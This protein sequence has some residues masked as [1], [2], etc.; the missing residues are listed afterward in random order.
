MLK[1]NFR[2]TITKNIVTILFYVFLL[3]PFIQSRSYSEMPAIIEKLYK[4][5]AL[6]SSTVI[7][8]D[9]ICSGRIKFKNNA[10]LAL[11][12]FGISYIAITLIM[13]PFSFITVIHKFYIYAAL[14]FFMTTKIKSNPDNILLSLTLIYVFL[15]V[16]NFVFM[17]IYPN[18][19]YTVES[20]HAAHF[21]GD[22][23][24]IGYVVIPGVVVTVLYSHYKYGM[25]KW[26]AI[27]QI[28]MAGFSF[29][30][31]LAMSSIVCF[32]IFVLLYYTA[33]TNKTITP[34]I[35][36]IIVFSAACLLFSGFIS[37]TL[38]AFIEWAFGKSVT[39]SGRLTLWEQAIDMII[40]SPLIGYGGFLDVGRF[41]SE[42]R[43]WTYPAHTTYLQ[44]LLDGG[45]V[46]LGLFMIITIIVFNN[47]NRYKNNILSQ[48]VSIGLFTIMIHYLFEQSGLFHLFILYCIA[49]NIEKLLERNNTYKNGFYKNA[50]SKK[51]ITLR[52]VG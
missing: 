35:F 52:L 14:L 37:N 7:Y 47:L 5:A 49:L 26:F 25:L 20:Y 43:M 50:R 44:L 1:R 2:F 34:H 42:N 28:V 33:R 10:L 39:F 30:S 48:I 15:T 3:F 9:I 31:R 40:Q 16:T 46:I 12:L 36:P 18:G 24:A 8:A 22:D 6:L 41:T 32:S 45:I 19:L 13:R 38:G 21:L 51:R 29:F 11:G 4:L 23:N 17:L 27:M